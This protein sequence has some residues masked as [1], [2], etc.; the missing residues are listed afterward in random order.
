MFALLLRPVRLGGAGQGR[1]REGAGRG[2]LVAPRRPAPPVS[3]PCPPRPSGKRIA[4]GLTPGSPMAEHQPAPRGPESRG[5]GG[6]RRGRA[7]TRDRSGPRKVKISRRHCFR[8]KWQ[9]GADGQG[10]VGCSASGC[11]SAKAGG[12]CCALRPQARLCH[13]QGCVSLR[14]VCNPLAK[15]D[16]SPPPHTHTPDQGYAPKR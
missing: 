7:L 1:T 13:R 10:R 16:K 12:A 11:I 2:S 6:D 4:P 8:D 15:T 9:I 5:R 14:H 3:P